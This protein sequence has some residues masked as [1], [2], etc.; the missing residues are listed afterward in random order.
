MRPWGPEMG[1]PT[2]AQLAAL[3]QLRTGAERALDEQ[4]ASVRDLLVG[5]EEY[6]VAATLQVL[7]DELDDI[8]IRA[9]L[10]LAL[11]RLAKGEQ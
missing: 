10:T 5:R 1:K 9:A 7:V 6:V 11:L 8:T 4:I 3:D 2:P